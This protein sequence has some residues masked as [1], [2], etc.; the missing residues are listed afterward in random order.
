MT[1][2]PPKSPYYLNG[3]E[4]EFDCGWDGAI[5]VTECGLVTKLDILI[6]GYEKRPPNGG[7]EL[8]TM[9]QHE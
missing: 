2:A 6:L 7:R 1:I 4:Q 9:T 5:M 3:S 8:F